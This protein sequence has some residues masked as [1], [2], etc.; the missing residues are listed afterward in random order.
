MGSFR[1]VPDLVSFNA[2]ILSCREEGQWQLAVHLLKLCKF[3]Y[4]EH[5]HLPST[6]LDGDVRDIHFALG[7]S[8]KQPFA[9][10]A[11]RNALSAFDLFP[12]TLTFNALL[13]ACGA[14]WPL[15]LACLREMQALAMVPDTISRLGQI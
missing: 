15:A 1:L 14:R 8:C 5:L 7:F 13:A 3:R 10:H 6:Q 4:G 9:M 12:E 11:S 2:T